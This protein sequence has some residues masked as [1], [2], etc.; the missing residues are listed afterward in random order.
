MK[1]LALLL[2]LL[3]SLA[4]AGDTAD[5][6]MLEGAR[7]FQAQQFTEALVEFRVA[8]RS[9][10]AGASW[11]IASTLVKLHRPEE[12]LE[13]FERAETAAARDRDALFDYYHALACYDARLYFC[14]DHLLSALGEQPGPRIA[15]Q[16]RQIRAELAHLVS[17]PPSTSAI[18]WYHTRAQAALSAG[19]GAL[20][21]SYY[22][23]ASSLAALRSDGYRRKEA[24]AGLAR[25]RARIAQVGVAP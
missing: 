5:E 18:D 24:L 10:D 12:A 2:A 19:R 23:E 22:D 20:A 14:A 15:A 3:P 11:Y 13:A 8:E 7:Y 25:A 1:R 21:R 16:A 4:R 6:H 9:G 17:T